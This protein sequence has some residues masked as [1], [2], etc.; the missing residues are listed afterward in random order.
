MSGFECFLADVGERPS[1]EHS[2]DRIENELNY[3]PDNCKWSTVKEQNRNRRSTR[4]VEFMGRT[5]SLAEAIEL[6][7]LPQ[8]RVKRRLYVYKWTVDEALAAR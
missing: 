5:M 6:S 1:L 3:D 7:G 2:I 8:A 4:W